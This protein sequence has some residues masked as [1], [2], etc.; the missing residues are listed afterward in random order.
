MGE[1]WAKENNLPIERYPADWDNHGK[2]AGYRRNAEMAEN[3]EAL[4]ALWDFKSRGTKHMI[5]LAL[6]A[7]LVI[8]VRRVV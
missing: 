6:K 7:G 1:R 4:L 2:S 8:Y 3:A 5:D